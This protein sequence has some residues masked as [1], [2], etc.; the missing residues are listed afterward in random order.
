MYMFS[1][2]NKADINSKSILIYARWQSACKI[3]Q[4]NK[5]IHLLT[6]PISTYDMLCE[7]VR[8]RWA[9][10]DSKANE[11]RGSAN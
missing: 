11:I 6:C 8:S 2:V 10:S 1:P 7:C 3:E 9:D 4:I 5:N